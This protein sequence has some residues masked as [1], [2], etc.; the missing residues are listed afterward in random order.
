MWRN[1][2]QKKR[3]YCDD[4]VGDKQTFLD[5]YKAANTL[6]AKDYIGYKAHDAEIAKLETADAEHIRSKRRANA[7]YLFSALRGKGILLFDTLKPEDCPLHVPI[8]LPAEQRDRLRS[9]LTAQAVYCPAHWP[10]DENYPYRKTILHDTEISLVCDQR[11]SIENIKREAEIVLN[12]MA[13]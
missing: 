4:K 3:A 7:E 9:A 2:A 8:T 1:A 6:L 5:L 12:F 11:Y 10:V 13:E